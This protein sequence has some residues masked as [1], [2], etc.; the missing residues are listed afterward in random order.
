MRIA[1]LG[2]EGTF[3]NEAVLKYSKKAQIV[4]QKTVW[5]VFEAVKL[6]NADLGV[7]PIESSVSGTEGLTLDALMNFDLNIVG[8]EILPIKH[9]LAA[10]G[11][12]RDIKTIYAHP[13]THAQCER[14]LRE[15][16][17]DAEIIH[18]SSNGKSAE[19]LAKSQKAD[20]AAVIPKLASQKYKLNLIKE[21]IQDNKFNVT[22]FI[23]IGEK[24]PG[25]TGR[26]RTSITIYPQAD[27][28]GLLYELLGIFAKRKINLTKIESRP[29]KGKLGDYIFFID[30]QGHKDDK[31][32]KEAFS[33]I[34]KSFFLK[35]L[36]S[37]PRKY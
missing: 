24:C 21:A 5:D 19:L 20:K 36:G 16:L 33:I 29:S 10:F 6:K 15:N 12:P 26:D 28:P 31:N 4:F 27:R 37:Y 3:S 14:Y 25:K 1:T 17:P 2:P 9:N 7:A 30:L 23:I 11:A 35:V 34:E 8:E 22:R 18:T 13:Q 32:V